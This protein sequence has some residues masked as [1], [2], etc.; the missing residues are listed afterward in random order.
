M[1]AITVLTAVRTLELLGETIIG[2]NVV[3]DNLMLT[4]RSGLTINAG[5]V[6]GASATK[7]TATETA[8]SPASGI[9]ATNVQSALVELA[10]DIIALNNSKADKTAVPKV[11]SGRVSQPSTANAKTTHE[12]VNVF[13]SGFFASAPEVVITAN[14]TVPENIL[15]YSV[16]AITT[17]S[18]TIISNRNSTTNT[19]YNWIAVG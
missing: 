9:A 5:S 14:T 7:P 16:T 4:T 3:G 6:R 17:R 12:H 19:T 10:S 8:F 11:L 13:P 15:Y 18:F 1:G 2:A